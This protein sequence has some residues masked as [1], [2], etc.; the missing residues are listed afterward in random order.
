MSV[1]TKLDLSGNSFIDR[2]ID[3][4]YYKSFFDSLPQ[5]RKAS[6]EHFVNKS[7]TEYT[8]HKLDDFEVGIISFLLLRHYFML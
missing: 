6:F 3:T 1:D 7:F 4:S 2:F 8:Q 5:G